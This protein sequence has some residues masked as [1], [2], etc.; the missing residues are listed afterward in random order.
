MNLSKILKNEYVFSTITRIVA[1]IIAM[2][3]SIIVARFLGAELKGINAYISS[4]TSV[5]SI[6]ITFGFH[7]AYPYYRK[8]LGKDGFYQ[9]YISTVSIVYIIYIIIGIAATSLLTLKYELRIAF[10]LIPLFGYSKILDYV[11]LVEFPNKRNKWTTIISVIDIIY[12]VCLYAF[13]Y[14]SLYWGLSILV[15]ADLIKCVIFIFVL[16]IRI[17]FHKGLFSTLRSLLSFGF[18]PMLALLMTTLN[19]KIDV[20]MLHHY[21]CIDDAMIG[22]YSIGISLSDNVV[23]IPDTLKGVLVSKL[24]KGASAEEVA[25]VSRIGVWSSGFIFLLVTFCGKWAITMF[26]GEEYVQAYPVVLITA[27][28]VIT[29]VYFKFIAQYNIINNRQKLNVAMLSIAILTDIVLNC[30]FIPKWGIVGAAMATSIGNMVCGIVFVIYFCGITGI[31][32]SK[33]IIPQKNDI[34]FI[35]TFIDKK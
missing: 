29:V 28:G 7:H 32:I 27:I 11:T 22:A 9:D 30:L 17:C 35:K 24:A 33:M 23:L 31:S 16:R 26:Y 19:Y 25:K 10:I 6:V 2:L 21:D 14:R 8:K 3:Q 13:A 5:G 1:I 12:V 20:I 15:F 34:N 4:I 18:F